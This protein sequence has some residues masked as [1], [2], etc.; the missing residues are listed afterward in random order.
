M[1]NTTGVQYICATEY[2]TELSV[3]LVGKKLHGAVSDLI[4]MLN[5]TQT[6]QM[7]SGE[8]VNVGFTLKLH[9]DSV[10]RLFWTQCD[11]WC[12]EWRSIGG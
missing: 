4:I 10:P 6:L 3:E 2:S 12:I 9:G 5:S 8:R 1:L 11:R 7:G